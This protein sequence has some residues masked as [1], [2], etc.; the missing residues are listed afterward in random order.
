[1]SLQDP[2]GDMLSRIRNAQE[3]RKRDVAMPMS[4]QKAAV[5]EILKQEGYVSEYRVEGE[6]SKKSLV[7]DL[8][9]YEGKPVIERLERISRPGLRR[10]RTCDK[11]PKIRNGLGIAILSTPEGVISDRTAR[12]KGIGGELICI[13]T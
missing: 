1:M 13:V 3:R 10:Y 2:I 5:A 6:G 4:R 12:A 8:K 9:Y 7:I 11:L